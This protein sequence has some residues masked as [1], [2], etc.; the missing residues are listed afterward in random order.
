MAK[1]K[2]T[3]EEDLRESVHYTRSLIEAS[4]DMMLTFDRDGL[5]MDVNQQTVDATGVA[6]KKLIGSS[7]KEYFTDPETA[8]KAVILV[9]EQEKVRGWDMQLI[10]HKGDHVRVAL[11]ASIYR[12]TAGKVAGAFGI[13]RDISKRTRALEEVHRQQKAILE[14]STPALRVWEGIVLM[15]LIGT[16]DT[17]RAKQVMENLLQKIVS[18]ESQVA[19]LDIAGVPTMDTKVAQHLLATAQAAEMLG[20]ETIITGVSPATAQTMTKLGLEL[21]HLTF[22]GSLMAGL[23]EALGILGLK[24]LQSNDQ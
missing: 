4:P 1:K 24:V 3:A 9:F 13:V 2:K 19:I 22:K 10:D 14:L 15:P 16:I 23:K 21:S 20:A 17:R 8:H 11:N 12:D 18:T 7:F 5:I 6:K